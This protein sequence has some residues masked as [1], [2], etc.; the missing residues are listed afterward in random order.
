MPRSFVI[1][2]GLAACLACHAAPVT[3]ALQR[4]ALAV[5][6]PGRAVLLAA[7]QAGERIVAVGE[8]GVIALS[9]DRGARILTVTTPVRD[10][11]R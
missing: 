6:E 10:T 1:L 5:R 8:R 7:A 4:P 11:A 2:L 3:E 9:D